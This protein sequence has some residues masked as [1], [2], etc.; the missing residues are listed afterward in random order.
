AALLDGGSG[1]PA[2]TPDARPGAPAGAGGGRPDTSGWAPATRVPAP[3][4]SLIGRDRL[5]AEIAALV[6]PQRLVSLLGPGGVGKTRLLVEVGHLLR[7]AEPDR[8]VVL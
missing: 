8:P 1:A 7:A 3:A 6:G 2:G 5:A 4:T